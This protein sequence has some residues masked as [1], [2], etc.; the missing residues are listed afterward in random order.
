MVAREPSPLAEQAEGV[1]TRE[2]LG[3]VL[4]TLRRRH[5]RL[6]RTRPLTYRMLAAATGWSSASVGE[7]LAGRTLPP[8][9]RFDRLVLLL[10]ASPGEQRL[11]AD[12]RDRVEES[13]RR[14]QAPLQDP[15]LPSMDDLAR[16][17]RALSH[18]QLVEVLAASARAD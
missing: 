12:A 2:D 10:G 13:Q 17:L 15:P 14:P 9:D 18:E 16:W 3:R 11:L 4:R 6:R 1:A 5:A 8:T 7:Y